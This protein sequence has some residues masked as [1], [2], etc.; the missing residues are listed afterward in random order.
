[1]S[2]SV[3]LFDV[4]ASVGKPCTGGTGFP[5]VRERL[6]AMDRLGISRALVWNEAAGQNHALTSNQALIEEIRGTPGAA[7]RPPDG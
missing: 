4:N 3:P 7:G 5:T 2:Q 1:M 6:H